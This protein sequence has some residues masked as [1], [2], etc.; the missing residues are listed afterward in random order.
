[1]SFCGFKSWPRRFRFASSTTE[2]SG[3]HSSSVLFRRSRAFQGLSHFFKSPSTASPN[4]NLSQSNQSST[5]MNITLTEHVLSQAPPESPRPALQGNRSPLAGIDEETKSGIDASSHSLHKAS[6]H[7][8][9]KASN[10]AMTKAFRDAA[11]RLAGAAPLSNQ[12]AE[13]D[14]DGSSICSSI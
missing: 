5:D 10:D 14:D 8:N 6:S 7:S 4:R 1:M 13:D 11:Q 12:V 3:G 2:I 9:G